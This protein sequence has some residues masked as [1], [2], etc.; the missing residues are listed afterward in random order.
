[1]SLPSPFSRTQPAR[2]ARP[3]S[4][5]TLEDANKDPVTVATNKLATSFHYSKVKRQQDAVRR[6]KQ[7]KRQWL[8]KMY[9]EGLAQ[10]RATTTGAGGAG[11]GA[12][13]AGGGRTGDGRPGAGGAGMGGTTGTIADVVDVADEDWEEH[14]D[15]LLNW[16]S[17][18]DFDRCVAVVVDTIETCGVRL[19]ARPR[20]TDGW[21]SPVWPRVTRAAPRLHRC[22]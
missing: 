19:A 20:C 13:G 1:M 5:K 18:L 15:H 10:E 21:H 2:S 22:N 4:L 14:A 6:R 17:T 12:D 11:A 9:K 16:S 3:T 7:R 8:M